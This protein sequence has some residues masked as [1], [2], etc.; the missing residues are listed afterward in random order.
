MDEED[1][2]EQTSCK[3]TVE[4]VSVSVTTTVA[5]TTGKAVPHPPNP[6]QSSESEPPFRFRKKPPINFYGKKKSTPS[7]S[8]I[9]SALS[10]TF[11]SRCRSF[12]PPSSTSSSSSSPPSSLSKTS[13]PASKT[14]SLYATSSSKRTSFSGSLSSRSQPKRGKQS[15]PKGPVEVIDLTIS[16]DDD[17]STSKSSI[18]AGQNDSRIHRMKTRSRLKHERKALHGLMIDLTEDDGSGVDEET[19]KDDRPNPY[20]LKI[21]LREVPAVT[22]TGLQRVACT[23]TERELLDLFIGLSRPMTGGSRVKS[24]TRGDVDTGKFDEMVA[25]FMK[26]GHSTTS[27]AMDV[28]NDETTASPTQHSQQVNGFFKYLRVHD[29]NK[30][31]GICLVELNGVP[32]TASQIRSMSAPGTWFDDETINGYVQ[33]LAK[34]HP[35]VKFLNTFF[36]GHLTGKG[37]NNYDY[38][39]VRRWTRK[40]P[41]GIFSFDA[42]VIPINRGNSH[43]CMASIHIATRTIKFYDSMMGS[44]QYGQSVMRNLQQYLLDEEIDKCGISAQPS[45]P[46]LENPVVS[47]ETSDDNVDGDDAMDEDEPATEDPK[48]RLQPWTFKIERCPQ[49]QDG[50]RKK[51]DFQA[52]G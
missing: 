43:W 52:A 8:S 34:A 42:V 27:T 11:D 32:V 13:K 46:V 29:M 18:K 36:Y 47:E 6:A 22:M 44:T 12:S 37:G 39:R 3:S 17:V 7:S 35:N 24:R 26:M 48:D 45:A 21:P 38:E 16:S 4:S 30:F 23:E 49:Q 33:L 10:S 14:Q 41:K 31:V 5:T 15:L 50:S 28:D 51:V 19:D 1:I 25:W 20:V 40:I 2:Q 9:P